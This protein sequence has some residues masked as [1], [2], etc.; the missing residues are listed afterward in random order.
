MPKLKEILCGSGAKSVR[1]PKEIAKLIRQG[2]FLL[3]VRTKI[4]A[5]KDMAPGATNI[6]LLRLKRHLDDL[7][8]NKTI[9]TYCGTGER[10]GKAKDI[11][12]TNG[13]NVVN[14]GS[15]SEILKILRSPKR[16][17]PL[18]DRHHEAGAVK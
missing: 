6:P 18:P 5:R 8:R 15:Y 1:P 4:E 12:E 2:A 13:F 11:L 16:L 7:P 10:A 14:G 9:V 17:S 3:D